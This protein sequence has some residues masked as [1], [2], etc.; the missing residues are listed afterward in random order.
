MLDNEPVTKWNEFEDFNNNSS[1]SPALGFEFNTD[2][3]TNEIAAINNVLEEFKNT[4]YSSSVDIDKY[5]EKL[6]IKLK[7]QGIEKVIR[8]MQSQLNAWSK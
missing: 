4:L 7:E 3:V 5:L 1:I 6:N 8:Q 2:P